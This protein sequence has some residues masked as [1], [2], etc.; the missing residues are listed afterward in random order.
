MPIADTMVWPYARKK[1]YGSLHMAYNFILFILLSF[2]LTT[3]TTN[4]YIS[5]Q[6]YH[7]RYLYS[8]DW[9]EGRVLSIMPTVDTTT[10]M[11]DMKDTA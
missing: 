11:K 9:T 8:L 6:P 10:K 1:M 7:A 3:H 5:I 2:H 4:V